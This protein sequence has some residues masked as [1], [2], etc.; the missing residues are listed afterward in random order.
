MLKILIFHHHPSLSIDQG[1]ERVE[2]AGAG[3]PGIPIDVH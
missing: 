3:A 1:I 2:G